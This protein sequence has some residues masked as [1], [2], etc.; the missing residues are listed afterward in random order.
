MARPTQPKGLKPKAEG[1]SEEKSGF[2]SKNKLE[3]SG[4]KLIIVNTIITILVCLLFVGSNYFIIKNFMQNSLH[5]QNMSSGGGYDEDQQGEGDHEEKGI[6]LDLGEFILN[7]N[8]LSAKRYLKI[9]VAIELSRT[10]S[11]PNPESKASGGHGGGHGEAPADPMKVFEEE[12][13]Q[14]K[15]AIRDSVISA[16][17]SRTAEELSSIA[18]KELAKEQIK[19]A[20]N[21]I[22]GGEREVLRVSFGNFIIQ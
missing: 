1:D 16:L 9:D 7:L 6:I 10:A 11:D 17:S 15:P 5:N 14:Y 19:E 4:M 12:M 13:S 21:A 20:I 3:L 18:G 2:D 8:D 22:F